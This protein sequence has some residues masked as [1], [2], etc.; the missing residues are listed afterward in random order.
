MKP[1]TSPRRS[2]TVLSAG[3]RSSAWERIR[4]LHPGDIGSIVAGLPRN[5][6]EAMVHAMTPDTVLWMLRQMNPVVAGRVGTRLGVQLLTFALRQVHPSQALATLR[7]IPMLRSREVAESLQQPQAATELL[8][9]SLDTAGS[10]MTAVLPT[11]DIDEAARERLRA[12]EEIRDK[13]THIYAL[14]EGGSLAGQI[15]IVDLA[16]ADSEDTIRSFATSIVATVKVETP[17]EECARLQRHYN[18]TQLPV[19][20]G[21]RLTGVILA[22]SLLSATVE[23]D[24]RQMQQVASVAGVTVDGALYD[25]I[26]TRLPW[27][28]VNLGT[29]FLAA[30][31]VALFESTLTQV[32]V[33]AAFLP[34]VAG[35]GGKG[36]TQTLTL[37]VRAI[38]L[39]GVGGNRRTAAAGPG[40]H[41][42][43][44]AW[45]LARDPGR[46]NRSSLEA[47]PRPGA[48]TGDIYA[49]Q[50]DDRRQCRDG[51]ATVPAPNRPG[52]G[53]RLRSASYD[54]YG[55]VRLP[56]VPGHRQGGNQPHTLG[57]ANCSSF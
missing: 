15:S 50:H 4:H 54:G 12:V 27:L 39:G 51:G 36:G 33:L 46:S 42:R 19:V 14:G 53:G 1:E 23:H 11:V 41:P 7:R 8:A 10:L 37:I 21:D 24:T 25:S 13:L 34:M 9:Y 30:A 2:K 43:D 47:E 18:L 29:T 55:R 3:E 32:I 57:Q 17:V 44:A 5:S 22:E 20:E 6:R 56:A 48:C 40:G 28:T 52:S 35:Q 45:G 16:L 31:T 38:A 49:R 26:R